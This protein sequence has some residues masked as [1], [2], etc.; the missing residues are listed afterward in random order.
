MSIITASKCFVVRYVTKPGGYKDL[1]YRAFRSDAPISLV[2]YCLVMP[3]ISL[4]FSLSIPPLSHLSCLCLCHI[5]T[6]LYL[7]LCL[8][9]YIP[10]VLYLCCRGPT[11][12]QKILKQNKAPAARSALY[13]VFF[14]V[15]APQ[16]FFDYLSSFQ[17]H[18][19][20]VLSLWSPISWSQDFCCCERVR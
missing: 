20:R 8:L 14:I 17:G 15:V 10:T 12:G 16:V 1:P 11:C 18:L 13:Q 5:P 7:S 4:S 2:R 3:H 9:C 6:V 19:L